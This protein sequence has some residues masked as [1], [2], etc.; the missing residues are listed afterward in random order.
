M[1]GLTNR[2]LRLL[3]LSN[4]LDRLLQPSFLMSRVPVGR[5]Q[6]AVAAGLLRGTKSLPTDIYRRILTNS[7]VKIN[8]ISH[9]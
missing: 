2:E 3:V 6:S 5:E 4:K 1:K 7:D 8:V 9:V